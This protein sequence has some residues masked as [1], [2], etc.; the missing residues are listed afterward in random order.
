MAWLVSTT[1][2]LRK[3]LECSSHPLAH[4]HA[5][6]MM[7]GLGLQIAAVA[8]VILMMT[9]GNIADLMERLLLLLLSLLLLQH[10]L[11]RSR[12]VC[13]SSRG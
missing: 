13:P 12:G 5:F 10:V 4:A 7:S 6:G 2:P 9:F 11:N 1:L 3:A 8:L